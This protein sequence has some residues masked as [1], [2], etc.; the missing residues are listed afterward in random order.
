MKMINLLFFLSSLLINWSKVRILDGPPIAT[1]IQAIS[2]MASFF[3]VS[4]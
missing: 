1:N 2:L 3:D 4:V